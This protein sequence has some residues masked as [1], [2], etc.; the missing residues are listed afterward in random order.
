MGPLPTSVRLVKLLSILGRD[1]AP[2]DFFIR[3]APVVLEEV[4]VSADGNTE[5]SNDTLI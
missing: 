5:S 1:I 4:D 2:N 3:A